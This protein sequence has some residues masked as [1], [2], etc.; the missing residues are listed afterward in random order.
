MAVDTQPVM[1]ISTCITVGDPPVCMSFFLDSQLSNSVTP[2][3]SIAYICTGA[4]K[5][6]L[7]YAGIFHVVGFGSNQLRFSRAAAVPHS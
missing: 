6:M 2:D 5:P 3:A 4:H 7:H 1:K